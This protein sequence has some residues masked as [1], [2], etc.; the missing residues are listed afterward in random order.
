MGAIAALT[1][2]AVAVVSFLA[3]AAAL[4]TMP[5]WLPLMIWIKGGHK[6]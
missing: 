4:A 2:A 3:A 6:S 1:F 5:L